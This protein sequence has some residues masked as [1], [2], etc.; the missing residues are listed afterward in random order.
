MEAQHSTVQ[1]D[2]LSSA[3]AELVPF[4]DGTGELRYRAR[5]A[6]ERQ[7][8]LP[9]LLAEILLLLDGRRSMEEVSSLLFQRTGTKLSARDIRQVIEQKLIPSG[10]VHSGDP[11]PSEPQPKA[12]KL[13]VRSNWSRLQFLLR[14]PLFSEKQLAPLVGRLTG[15]FNWLPAA[16]CLLLVLFAHLSFYAQPITSRHISRLPADLCLS[17][18]IIFGSMFFHELGHAAASR[19]FGCEHGDIGFTLY[20]IFPGLYADMSKAW[21][22]SGW[23]RAIIDLGGVYFQLL[24]VVPLCL[25]QRFTGQPYYATP[26]Y[27]ID[28]MVM[29]ALNPLFKFDGYWLLVDLSGLANLQQRSFSFLKECFLSFRNGFPPT[30]RHVAGTARRVIL[31]AYACTLGLG[32]LVALPFLVSRLPTRLR[33]VQESLSR[34]AQAFQQSPEAALL[35]IGR[36]IGSLF[37][38][39]FF[40]RLVS[41]IVPRG[42]WRQKPNGKDESP[43]PRNFFRIAVNGTLLLFAVD[44]AVVLIHELAHGTVALALG[45]QFSFFQ[46][47]PGSGRSVVILPYGAPAWKQSIILLSGHLAHLLIALVL[48]PVVWRMASRN[49]WRF[50]AALAGVSA[51]INTP[52]GAGLVNNNELNQALS[53]LEISA[54]LQVLI[55]TVWLLTELAFA[56]FFLRRLFAY[57]DQIEPLDNYWSRL[58]AVLAV[59]GLPWLALSIPYALFNHPADLK[60]NSI[61]VPLILIFILLFALPLLINA[62]LQSGS[63]PSTPDLSR[64]V[65]TYAAMAAALLLVFTFAFGHDRSHPR[66][67]FLSRHPAEI[68]VA[69]CNVKIHLDRGRNA[70][71]TFLMR[72]FVS[73][74][75]FLWDAVRSQPPDRWDYY[76]AFVADN[77]PRLLP[78]K[79]WKMAATSSAAESLFYIDGRWSKGS[80]VIEADVQL[81]DPG[82]VALND[83]VTVTDFWKSQ[84]LGNIDLVEV[85]FG[86]GLTLAELNMEPRNSQKPATSATSVRW[87]NP[88]Y[89]SAFVTTRLTVHGLEDSSLVMVK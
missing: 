13:N 40:Y 36:L 53:G 63:A 49:R 69:A 33:N 23:Q 76:E 75:S 88:T 35:E 43:V 77:L 62:K 46:M 31:A 80:R 38:L 86:H 50:I 65:L 22:L 85:E 21:R 18:L 37:F 14:L 52:I 84:R 56:A 26:I 81:S 87:L 60:S 4:N 16:A 74:H 29:F 57:M 71:V 42:L 79:S 7:F 61:G 41:M 72:P 68:T 64:G 24:V 67:I 70:H 45:G 15:L 6:G 5:T 55:K 48:I 25:L 51:S 73:Q 28:L 19:R 12:Q 47:F 58:R 2:R 89:Q 11:I 1:Q 9:K 17:Y 66:G 83:T 82:R 54:S 39:L 8:L 32:I 78:V 10:L 30:L 59:W 27:A 34:I 3:V 44:F 20:L